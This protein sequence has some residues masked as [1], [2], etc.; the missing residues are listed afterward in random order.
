MQTFTDND[1]M[2]FRVHRGKPMIDVPAKYL[3]WL[4]NEGCSHQGVKQ[5][6]IENLD[7]LNK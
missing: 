4:Y 3:I 7:A 5:Y 6:I 2:P 1:L